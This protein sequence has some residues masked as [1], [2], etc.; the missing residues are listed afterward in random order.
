MDGSDGFL[1]AQLLN[2][3]SEKKR[4][5]QREE[6]EEE[7]EGDDLEEM[8]VA[9]I[10]A[11]VQIAANIGLRRKNRKPRK[12]RQ[13]QKMFWGNGY[14]NW[15][16]DEF[17]GWLHINRE[18]FMLILARISPFI[19]KKPTN[20]IPNPV[21]DHRQLAM[22]LFRLGHGCSF[23]VLADVFGVSIS[24]ATETFNKVIREIV[25]NL[26]DEYIYMP[27]TSEEW[28]QECNGFIENYEFPCVE[29]ETV[30]DI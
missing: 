25:R 10:Q 17:K 6:E 26:Y 5:L 23:R 13:Q 14:E 28:I 11:T 22:T 9:S 18:T 19:S 15:D 3:F 20:F 8:I 12:N 29:H 4:K 2:S 24:L 21:E 7:L 16:M 1:Y 30:I 27:R